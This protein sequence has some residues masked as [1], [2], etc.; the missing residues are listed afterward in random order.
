[1]KFQKYF[2]FSLVS[3]NLDFENN[4]E[5]LIYFSSFLKNSFLTLGLLKKMQNFEP[6]REKLLRLKLFFENIIRYL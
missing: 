3:I 1:M 2:S 5:E 4:A 6:L